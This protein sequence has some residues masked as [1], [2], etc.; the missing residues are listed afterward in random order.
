VTSPASTTPRLHFV[1]GGPV[2]GL[3]VAERRVARPKASVVCVHGALD[4]GGSFAR[5]A[6]RLDDFDV[7]AYDRRGYQ[8]SRA[9]GPGDLNRHIDDLCALLER[10][11]ARSKVV[12]VGHSFGGLVNFGAALREPALVDLVV[13]F[14]APF[15]WLVRREGHRALESEDPGTEAERFFRRVMS[16][17]GWERLSEAQRESRRL[18]GPALLAD[19]ATVHGPRAPF[20][21]SLLR[22]PATYAYGDQ[23]TYYRT[24][25]L[26]LHDVN[27]LIATV[28]F[29]HAP[30]AAHLKNP[31][32]LA[33]LVRQRWEQTCA[34]A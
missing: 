1:E 27:P 26:A 24:L 2:P 18:D 10:E 5:L 22:V 16:D 29:H 31:D 8:G 25:A 7:V 20:D 11:A 32:Q 9:L 4:R 17:R 30:H 12:V 23:G 6:R 33:R 3:A 15:P 14:E 19:L 34:S 13:N 28:E 21:V